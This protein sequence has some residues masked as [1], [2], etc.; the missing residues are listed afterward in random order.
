MLEPQDAGVRLEVIDAAMRYAFEGSEPESLSPL[1]R[2]MFEFIKIQLNES[3]GKWDSV[4]E[5]RK[6][7]A[8]KSHEAR[9]KEEAE[10]VASAASA[11]NA[12]NA[13]VNVNVNGN[14]NVNVNGENKDF[15]F[16]ENNNGASAYEKKE[17]ILFQ[18]SLLFLSKGVPQ[19][20][21]E[22]EDYYDYNEA[23]GWKT[24]NGQEILDRVAYAKNWKTKHEPIFPPSDGDIFANGLRQLGLFDKRVINYFRGFRRSGADL[25]ALFSKIIGGNTLILAMKKSEQGEAVYKSFVDA[26]GATGNLNTE[27]V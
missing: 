14:G 20:Y 3:K 8:R 1:A 24:K 10:T 16:L 7:A 17:K 9:K 2:G 15:L 22:A 18:I 26:F 13:A 25:V 5:K 11:A 4:R 12:A 6:E 19:A 27:K 23:I 21:D